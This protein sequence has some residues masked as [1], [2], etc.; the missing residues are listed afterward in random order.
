MQLDDFI[1]ES[2]V[3]IARGVYQ[4]NVDLRVDPNLTGNVPFL[5][6]LDED[7]KVV[8]DVAVTTSHSAEA[9]GGGKFRVLV[10]DAAADGKAQFQ[11]ERVS[12]LRFSVGVDQRLGYKLPG[13]SAK[14]P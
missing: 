10:V 8:F 11:L 2:L 5:I 13:L 14:Q 6:D 12:R 4:A 1:R 3:Q 7:G 9:S